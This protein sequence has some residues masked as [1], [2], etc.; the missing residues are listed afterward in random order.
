[1]MVPQSIRHIRRAQDKKKGD[2]MAYTERARRLRRC[3]ATRRDGERCNAYALWGGVLCSAHTY[4]TRGSNERGTLRHPAHRITG[5]P[6]KPRP[7]RCAAYAWPHRPGAGL[8]RW[9]DAPARRCQTPAGTHSLFRTYK[10]RYRA[11][12]RR[13]AAQ[14]W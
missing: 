6:T 12:E 9:P 10:R 3:T 1:M 13:W 11:L 7:C 8:C 14:G 4:R 5:L 2:T